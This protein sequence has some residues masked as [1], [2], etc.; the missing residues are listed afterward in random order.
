[1]SEFT[2]TANG[3]IAS[4]NDMAANNRWCSGYER[5]LRKNVTML[6]FQ[7]ADERELFI[8]KKVVETPW[9]AR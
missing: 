6:G 8:L 7:S 4:I 2:R 1:M 3:C 5:R 9:W